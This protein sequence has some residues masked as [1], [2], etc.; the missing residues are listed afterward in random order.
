MNVSKFITYA[1]LAALAVLVITHP[2]GFTQVA[3]AG[4]GQTQKFFTTFTGAG[5]SGGTTGSVTS[6][7]SN[8]TISG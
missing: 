3:T 1:F 2:V 4:G 6:S 8:Y 7:G 5:Q